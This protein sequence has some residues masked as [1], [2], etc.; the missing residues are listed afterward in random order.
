MTRDLP[1]QLAR[2]AL[3]G[4][5]VA[6]GLLVRLVIGKDLRGE[7]ASVNTSSTSMSGRKTYI[8]MVL[9]DCFADLL[10]AGHHTSGRCEAQ[11]GS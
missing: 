4:V 5:K 8:P 7:E 3:L 11:E 2:P 6:S 1:D 10:V 9:L